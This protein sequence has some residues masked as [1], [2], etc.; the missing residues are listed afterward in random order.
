MTQLIGVLAFG[1]AMILFGVLKATM[2]IRMHEEEE[3]EGLDLAEHGMHGY[4]L[5][6]SGG[7]AFG[8]MAGA[9]A[10][11]TSHSLATNKS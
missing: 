10:P 5:G 7:G 3:V 1:A 4:D 9:H 11:V 8:S 2:G 6:T